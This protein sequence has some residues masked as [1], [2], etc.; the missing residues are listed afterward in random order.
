[1][2]T[3]NRL[4]AHWAIYL[5]TTTGYRSVRE[6]ILDWAHHPYRYGIS[7]WVIF[8]LHKPET[9]QEDMKLSNCAQYTHTTKDERQEA[10]RLVIV[11]PD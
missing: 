2:Y 4:E 10:E 1:M 6:D 11:K 3:T 9:P 5:Y 7:L 8:T